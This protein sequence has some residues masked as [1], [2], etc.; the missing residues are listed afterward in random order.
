MQNAT[1]KVS[2]RF[3]LFSS[4]IEAEYS[5]HRCCPRGVLT[6]VTL[7]PKSKGVSRLWLYLKHQTY[8]RLASSPFN[9]P[10]SDARSQTTAFESADEETS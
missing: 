9:S 8:T 6:F 7:C 4:K 1:G 2:R 3:K 5:F 10:C